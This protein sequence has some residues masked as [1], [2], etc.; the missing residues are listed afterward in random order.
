MAAAATH[1]RAAR[2]PATTPAASPLRAGIQNKTNASIGRR[3]LIRHGR[4]IGGGGDG[5]VLSRPPTRPVCAEPSYV[6]RRVRVRAGRVS[7]DNVRRK[8]VCVCGRRFDVR[9]HTQHTHIALGRE[10]LY[11]R[12]SDV[13]A[14]AGHNRRRVPVF[15]GKVRRR[16]RVEITGRRD[17]VVENGVERRVPSS[18]FAFVRYNGRVTNRSADHPASGRGKRVGLY[19]FPPRIPV[20][21]AVPYVM[22][23][24]RR[25]CTVA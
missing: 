13:R 6:E 16:V 20:R 14:A 4:S 3:R 10:Q 24:V 12:R 11:E 15:E 7:I 1:V 17:R 2:L 23:S 5:D 25:V 8:R 22:M 9:A 21:A 19:F 18:T